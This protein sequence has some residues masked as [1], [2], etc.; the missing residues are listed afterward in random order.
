LKLEF[1]ETTKIMHFLVKI[2]FALEEAMKF[3][4]GNR[5]VALLF[6]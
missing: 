1:D 2:K 6:L 5:D 4:T 3:Q